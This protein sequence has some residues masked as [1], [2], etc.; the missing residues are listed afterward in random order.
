MLAPLTAMSC[1]ERVDLAGNCL[2]RVDGLAGCLSLRELSLA[3]NCLVQV[4][5]MDLQHVALVV[6]V[7][8]NV[9]NTQLVQRS[10]KYNSVIGGQDVFVR[11]AG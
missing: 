9:D 10:P 5:C 11:Q 4:G 7:R 8:C 1:L 2:V 3:D 6:V